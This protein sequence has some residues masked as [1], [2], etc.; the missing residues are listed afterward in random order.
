MSK[1]RKRN[2]EKETITRKSEA[3]IR[4][5]HLDEGAI[6]LE[7]TPHK[8][9][10]TMV[11]QQWRSMEKYGL[12]VTDDGCIIPHK[13]YWGSK[14]TRPAS[15]AL[16]PQFF[17][18]EK[19]KKKKKNE[20]NWPCDEQY[21]HLCHVSNCA[22]P[23]CIIIEEQWK[24]LKR[25]YCGIKGECD[26]GNE[27]ECTRTFRNNEWDWDFNFLNYDSKELSKKIKEYNDVDFKI[28]PKNHYYN[29]D[30]KRKNRNI[31]RL[32]EKKQK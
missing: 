3:D 28:L 19:A 18:N 17:R 12:K 9:A 13:Q 27:I 16:V 24:N 10:S 20:L 25:N 29:E 22:S 32:R 2:E 8:D 21:S 4:N 11:I 5:A 6:L 23:S 26:C 7:F 30:E 14:G 15:R 1:K 31:R